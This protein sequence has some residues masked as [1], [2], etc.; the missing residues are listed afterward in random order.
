[1][2]IRNLWT[3]TD[4]TAASSRLAVDRG[5][6]FAAGGCGVR[7]DRVRSGRGAAGCTGEEGALAFSGVSGSSLDG[8]GGDGPGDG[9]GDALAASLRGATPFDLWQWSE[10][11]SQ[12]LGHLWARI[13]VDGTPE[14]CRAHAPELLRLVRRFLALRLTVVAADRRLA[15]RRRVPPADG[16]A[17]AALWAEVFWAARA[18]EPDDDS[19]VLE[20]TDAAVRS[21]LGTAAVDLR[22]LDAVT[23]RWEWLQQVEETLDGLEVQAQVALETRQ[24]LYEHAREMRQ[25]HSP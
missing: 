17:V 16:A 11:T 4:R 1:M 18:E 13:L 24:E 10:E 21:L 6:L 3:G 14:A 9:P 2:S 23:V 7:H 22:D 19:G 25:L 15:F 5:G 8:P 20:E 12:R